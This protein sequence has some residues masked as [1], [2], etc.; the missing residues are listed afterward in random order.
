MREYKARR[1]GNGKA[2]NQGHH[3]SSE[4]NQRKKFHV[5]RI[6]I[7][8]II[9]CHYEDEDEQNEEN[10]LK[11]RAKVR[12]KLVRSNNPKPLRDS[13]HRNHTP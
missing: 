12:S 8:R 10:K 5:T 9:P 13:G 2:T 11:V 6:E 3:K 7:I 4:R 1:H